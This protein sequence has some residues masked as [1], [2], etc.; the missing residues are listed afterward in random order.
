MRFQCIKCVENQLE[1]KERIKYMAIEQE[2]DK[3]LFKYLRE[4]IKMDQNVRNLI[5][6]KSNKGTYYECLTD[7]IAEEAPTW[8]E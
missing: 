5:N 3:I 7:L 2:Q 4:I 1:W 8:E 6:F